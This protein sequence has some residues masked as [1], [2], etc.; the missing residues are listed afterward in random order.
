MW[1]RAAGVPSLGPQKMACGGYG[2]C[3]S[4]QHCGRGHF[5]PI[6]PCALHAHLPADSPCLSS[7]CAAVQAGALV[8]TLYPS[9]KPCRLDLQSCC[10]PQRLPTPASPC[11]PSPVAHG[12]PTA[13]L[14]P[15]S[16]N[17]Q[18]CPPPLC[19]LFTLRLKCLCDRPE[20]VALAMAY[21]GHTGC[22]LCRPL[23]LLSLL[24]GWLSLY[25]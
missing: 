10:W 7:A 19:P 17:H 11:P 18:T 12:L 14:L 16:W 1:P 24:S 5:R 2:L 20:L 25:F 23:H 4:G 6:P 21:S 22:V 8:S 3:V 13:E 15:T 9:A